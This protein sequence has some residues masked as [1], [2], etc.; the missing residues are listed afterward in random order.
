MSSGDS[1]SSLR[2]QRAESDQL[3][4]HPP[5]PIL[6]RRG[7][8]AVRLGADLV[9]DASGR[10]QGTE[11]GGFKDSERATTMA[12]L[13]S[14]RR[15]WEN[16][17][18]ATYLLSRI[19]F[20]AN[21]ITIGD[22]IG[23]DTICTLFEPKRVKDRAQLFP[24]HSFALQVKSNRRSIGASGKIGFLNTLQLPFF[25]G[26]VSRRDSSIAIYSGEFLPIMFTW[27]G[28]PTKLT[29]IPSEVEDMA[30]GEGITANGTARRMKLPF[31]VRLSVSDS[32]S[33]C[34]DKRR[35][36]DRR[37]ERMH[38]NIASRTC[39][40]YIYRLDDAGGIQMQ[41]GSGSAKTFRGNFYL[42]LAEVFHNLNWL[43]DAR[44]EHFRLAEFDIYKDLYLRLIEDGA[45]LPDVLHVRYQETKEKVDSI[46]R[47]GD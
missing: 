47:G 43:I 25:L 17:H 8:P 24:L 15:G 20:L 5:L 21:P 28:I 23:A 7:F 10:T 9:R 30:V 2:W 18:L 22:D 39:E 34:N 31:L 6:D 42:K 46:R 44:P 38:K 14:F 35:Q 29:L 16:E 4:Q 11:F 12:H 45:G 40:Q 1:K 19:A 37:C 13:A 3:P 26:V 27:F 36:I 41:A 32:V 33:E